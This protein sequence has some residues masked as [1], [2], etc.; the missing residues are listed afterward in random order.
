MEIVPDASIAVKYKREV[1]K[2][3]EIFIGVINSYH[4]GINDSD[5]NGM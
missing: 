4:C 2:D 5:Y 3:E 1:G